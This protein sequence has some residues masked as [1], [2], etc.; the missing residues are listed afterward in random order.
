VKQFLNHP[1]FTVIS[2]VTSDMKLD[3]YVVGGFV[4][5]LIL[6]RPSHDI[7]IVVVGNAMDV[8]QKVAKELNSNIQV[9]FFKN[10]GTAMFR[11]NDLDIEFVGARKE[12]YS[13]NSRNPEVVMG[14]LADDQNRRDFTINALAISLNNIDFGKLIDPFNGIEHLKKKIIKTPLKADQTF[15]DDP[16]RMLRA[17]RFATQLKFQI[18]N[19]TFAAIKANVSRLSIISKER[20]ADEL[21]KIILAPL[22]SYGFLLLDESDILKFIFPQLVDLKGIEI[23]GKNAHKDNFYHTLEVLDNVAAK[24]E[25]LWLR[26]AAILHDIAKPLTKKYEENIGWTFHGHEFIGS[27]MV[28]PIF[29]QLALPL[30]EKMKYVAKL[31]QLHL[32]PIALSEESV[33]DSAFRRLLFDAANDIDDLMLLCEADIS[34]KNYLKKNKFINNFRAVRQK[35]HLIEENDRLR[36]WQP[37]I[38]GKDIMDTFHIKPSKEVGI[39]KTAIREAIIDGL[40]KN[41]YDEAYDFMLKQ[42]EKLGLFPVNN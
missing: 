25:N 7:D 36:N 41:N 27:K 13:K 39:I 31:V 8:A 12:S 38:S 32:R 26:W 10:F 19:D 9:Q 14:T 1:V 29:K 15:S 40:I 3:A 17:V 42:G 23:I 4:R 6:E 30:N 28:A 2:E 18:E 34:S 22:P 33:T 37:P 24:S 20:I 16:L 35:L 11:F 5:D 21:N